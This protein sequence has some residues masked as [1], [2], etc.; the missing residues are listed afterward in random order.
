MGKLK[1]KTPA[2]P[3]FWIEPELLYNQQLGKP[4]LTDY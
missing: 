4:V 1:S 2:V 3:G